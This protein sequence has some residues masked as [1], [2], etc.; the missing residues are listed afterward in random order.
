MSAS[1]ACQMPTLTSSFEAVECGTWKF[2]ARYSDG[3]KAIPN[4]PLKIVCIGT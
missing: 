4:C 2:V 1:G 3:N